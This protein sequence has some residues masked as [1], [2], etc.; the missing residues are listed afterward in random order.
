MDTQLFNSKEFGSVRTIV[1]NN[2]PL[3]CGSD[4]AKALGYSNARD[5]IS[6]HC[7]GVVK[8]DTPTKSGQQEMSFIPEGD[9]YRLVTHSKLPSAERFE[10]WVFDEVLP[11]IRKT[12]AY[13]HKPVQQQMKLEEPYHYEYKTWHGEQV[14]TLRDVAELTGT[15]LN[16]LQTYMNRHRKDFK[17]DEAQ[18]LT[19]DS[20]REFRAENPAVR[21]G[22]ILALWVLTA[23]GTKKLLAK[24]SQG[25]TIWQDQKPMRKYKEID[26]LTPIEYIQGEARAIMNLTRAV[27]ALAMRVINA[28]SKIQ[29]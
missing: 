4:V 2:K 16:S 1:D 15:S 8:R 6:R 17:P 21:M 26:G 11:V 27:E 25:L 3:F 29:V 19:V 28:T 12:G 22:R 7:R 14:V 9:V 24:P 5:A 23:K 10:R 13:A 18:M 20:I